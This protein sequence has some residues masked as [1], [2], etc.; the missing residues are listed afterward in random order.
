MPWLSDFDRF[1]LTAADLAEATHAREG[2]KLVHNLTDRGIIP[3]RKDGR[4]RFYSFTSQLAF[5]TM[6]RARGAGLPLAEGAKLAEIV[7]DRAKERIDDGY[8]DL[9]NMNGWH[10]LVYAFDRDCDPPHLIKGL[11]ER[12]DKVRDLEVMLVSGWAADVTSLFPIDRVIWECAE[13]YDRIQK[14]KAEKAK[15]PP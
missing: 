8:V 4:S 5:D 9:K 2:V 15:N 14:R 11:A 10:W 1:D 13:S 3:F 7:I 12:D 6:I